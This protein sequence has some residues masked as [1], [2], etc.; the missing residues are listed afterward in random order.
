MASGR[1]RSPNN[2][3]VADDS[4]GKAEIK[5]MRAEKTLALS[6]LPVVSRLKARRRHKVR[7]KSALS[8]GR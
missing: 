1:S 5:A 2:I 8:C 7:R 3:R 6:E 4:P